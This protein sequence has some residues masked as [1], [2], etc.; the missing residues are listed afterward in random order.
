MYGESSGLMSSKNQAGGLYQLKANGPIIR[1][2]VQP[3]EWR[4]KWFGVAF[5][6]HLAVLTVYGILFASGAI[7]LASDKR[8]FLEEE[9]WETQDAIFFFGNLGVAFLVAPILTILTL[10][11]LGK[12]AVLITKTAL[13]GSLVLNGVFLLVSLFTAPLMAIFFGLMLVFLG[14]YVIA[15]WHRIPFAA[16]NLQTSIAALQANKGIALMS[17]FAVPIAAIYGLLWIYVLTMMS[18][19]KWYQKHLTTVTDSDGETYEDVDGIVKFVFSLLLICF[20]WSM[21]VIFNVIH[22]TVAGTVGTW[23][24][25]PHVSLCI[26]RSCLTFLTV[27]LSLCWLHT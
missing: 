7:E 20:Y 6:I 12:H 21:Q 23:W 19:T 9:D 27:P 4:D 24:F 2:E 16:A 25:V 10:S 13:I 18:E 17:L 11:Q 1:G 15:V 8:R 14:C 5:W 3:L 26:Y 22:T